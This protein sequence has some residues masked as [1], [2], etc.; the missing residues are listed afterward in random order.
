M[1][2]KN[3]K[4]N[5]TK[6]GEFYNIETLELE[7]RIISAWL[8]RYKK[9]YC[10]LHQLDYNSPIDVTNIEFLNFFFGE[11]LIVANNYRY[12]YRVVNIFKPEFKDFE[13]NW[14]HVINNRGECMKIKEFDYLDLIDDVVQ[15]ENYEKKMSMAEMIADAKCDFCESH[16]SYNNGF[17]D[18]TDSKFLVYFFEEF[19]DLIDD[20]G[21]EWLYDKIDEYLNFMNR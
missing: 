2:I 16:S 9:K 11:Y 7:V 13:N 4:L 1:K 8:K 17:V 5:K 14:S 10:M 19:T 6:I 18:V 15:D 20:N 21:G 3:L 12:I